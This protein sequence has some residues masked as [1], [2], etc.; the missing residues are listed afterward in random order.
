VQ[1]GHHFVDVHIGQ[2]AAV[3]LEPGRHRGI[4]TPISDC[5]RYRRITGCLYELAISQWR[6][7]D[8]LTFQAVADSAVQQEGRR[9]QGLGAHFRYWDRRA[10][11]R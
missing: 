2:W 4:W 7:V 9:R 8:P 3:A 10:T 1:V 11:H 5:R 6:H